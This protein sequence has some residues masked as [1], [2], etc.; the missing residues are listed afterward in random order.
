MVLP[1]TTILKAGFNMKIEELKQRD[2]YEFQLNLS[3]EYAR[4]NSCDE[5]GCAF[6]WLGD[7]GVEYNFCINGTNCSAIYKMNFNGEENQMATDYDTFIH[8]EV[9]FNNENW[10]KEL[11]DSMCKAL[12]E[13]FDL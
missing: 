8:Y 1:Q 7:M 2:S 10:K 4:F 13:F 3:D 5:W 11:E 9:N 6:V 12:I